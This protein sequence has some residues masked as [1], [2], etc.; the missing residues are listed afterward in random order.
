MKMKT[1]SPWV[2]LCCPAIVQ[3]LFDS[4]STVRLL[5]SC[6]LTVVRL[7]SG[8]CPAVVWL[9][10]GCCS[11]AARPLLGCSSALLVCHLD[12]RTPLVWH[13]TVREPIWEVWRTVDQ[14][15]CNFSGKLRSKDIK[16]QPIREPSKAEQMDI[17][18]HLNQLGGEIRKKILE[19]QNEK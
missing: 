2:R 11:A 5:F 19:L 7:L 17:S 1:T 10:L 9:L 15:L 3:F 8:C 18:E 6:F 4:C 12:D 13:G 16:F 14:W